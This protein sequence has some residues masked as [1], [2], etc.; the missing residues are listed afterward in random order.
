MCLQEFLSC[1]FSI[2]PNYN[3]SKWF[4]TLNGPKIIWIKK[5][6]LTRPPSHG[7]FFDGSGGKAKNYSFF[8]ILLYNVTFVT[9]QDIISFWCNVIHF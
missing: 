7:S 1:V 8:Y 4:P 2:A 5:C 3:S 6:I 9:I